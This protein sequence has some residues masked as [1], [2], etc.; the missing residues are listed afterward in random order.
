M[1]NIWKFLTGDVWLPAAQWT[2]KDIPDLAGKVVVVTGG[3]T[4]IGRETARVHTGIGPLY[5]VC[6]YGC[7]FAAL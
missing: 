6:A 3:N 4:G 2:A 1:G 7:C 5:D